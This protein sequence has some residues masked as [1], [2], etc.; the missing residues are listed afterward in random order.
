M[1]RQRS[2]PLKAVITAF[3]RVSLPFLAVPLLSQR[4][5]AISRLQL[6]QLAGLMVG[7]GKQAAAAAEH[8]AR[9]AHYLAAAER[10]QAA[11]P[12]E[13]IATVPAPVTE[14]EPE[15]EPELEAPNPSLRASDTQLSRQQPSHGMEGGAQ[16]VPAQ[17][18]PAQQQSLAGSSAVGGVGEAQ[19]LRQI[20][21]EALAAEEA[22]E[23][24]QALL[25]Y[26]K[27]VQTGLLLSKRSG[28]AA[29]LRPEIEAC[30]DRAEALK[31]IERTGTG[32][33]NGSG[34]PGEEMASGEGDSCCSRG[35]L[36]S[37]DYSAAR[38]EF[39][40]LLER[41]F[42]EVEQSPSTRSVDMLAAAAPEA[43]GMGP[44]EVSAWFAKRR[45]EEVSSF[46]KAATEAKA[47]LSS[48]WGSNTRP[49]VAE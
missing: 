7:D 12:Q 20:A 43:A 36:D 15:P 26:Q 29:A 42:S 18:A 35:L 47:F 46:T 4:T 2:S 22:G 6:E 8:R 40:R 23:L 3:P 37:D 11:L 45:A 14:P 19:P 17:S 44:Q 30:L 10:L 32:G 27:A 49:A 16:L 25:L 9:A 33:G 21:A 5:V 38:D 28:V 39:V 41:H 24:D 13:T 1:V 34:A 31:H 48:L